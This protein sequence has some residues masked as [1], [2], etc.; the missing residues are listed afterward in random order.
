MYLGLGRMPWA[1]AWLFFTTTVLGAAPPGDQL[2]SL[3]RQLDAD[4][5]AVREE[6]SRNL[7]I[8]GDAAVGPLVDR[9]RNGDPGAISRA[10]KVLEQIA[11]RGGESTVQ[12]VS[13]AL[14]QLSQHGKPGLSVFADELRTKQARLRLERAVEK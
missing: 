10:A 2:R 12:R 8:A 13:T 5:E 3:V 6:A 9:L 7:L 4:D 14:D 1:I 11:T